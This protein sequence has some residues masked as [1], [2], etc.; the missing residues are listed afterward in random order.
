MC[1]EKFTTVGGVCCHNVYFLIWNSFS[2]FALQRHLCCECV[3]K[4]EGKACAN[5]LKTQSQ[6]SVQM[7]QQHNSLF[8]FFSFFF[9]FTVLDILLQHAGGD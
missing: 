1:V 6:S 9:F 8:A 2:F 4:Q 5:K 7:Q 3:L